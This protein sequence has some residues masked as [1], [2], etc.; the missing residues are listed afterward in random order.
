VTGISSLPPA[1]LATHE[2]AVRRLREA[3]AAVPPGVPVRL[4]KPTSNLFRYARDTA[5]PGQPAPQRVTLDVSAFASVIHVDAVERTAVVGGMTTYEDLCA[6]TL[7]HKLMPLVVPQLKTITLGGAVTGLGIESTSL[8]NGLPHES[9]TEMEILT[10]DGRVVT[11]TKDNEHSDLFYGFPNSYGTLGYSLALTIELM[12][13]KPYVHL[14]HFAFNDPEGCMAAIAEIAAA[15]SYH[16]HRAD[17]LDGVAFSGQELYLTVGA[18]SDKAPWLS[19]YTGQQVFYK[20][21]QATREDFLTIKDYIWR[22][23]T[24]WFWCSAAFGVQNSKVRPFWPRRYRRSDVYRKLVAFDQ[25]HGLTAALYE[26]RHQPAREMVVQDVEI[27]VERGREFLEFFEQNVKMAPVWLCPLRLRGDRTWP[28]YPMEPDEVY[29]N[30]GFW[31]TVPLPPGQSDG[32]Y[33]RMVEQETGALDGHK[34]LY[35]SA[36]YSEEEFR[37]RYNGSAYDKLKDEYDGGGRLLTLYDKCV[38]GR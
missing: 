8:W 2:A 14:R 35:S 5:R 27:P 37:S 31:G 10:G 13:V 18:F 25:K 4:A 24:D 11:A 26:R 15:G 28:L 19:D 23:D 34:S 20:S 36:F 33:N 16:G 21:L 6:A 12:P 1:K 38:R 22:W 7:P 3:Y 9:V 32:Y 30:F 17:F 29:V